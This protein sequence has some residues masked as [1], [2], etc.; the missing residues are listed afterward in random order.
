[1]SGLVASISHSPTSWCMS[2]WVRCHFNGIRIFLY[3]TQSR[4]LRHLDISACRG[5]Y[6]SE[7]QLPKL[8]SFC[9]S[10]SPLGTDLF[11][12]DFIQDKFDDRPCIYQ[13]LCT[14]APQLKY[15]NDHKL[16]PD[17]YLGIIYDELE[18]VLRGVCSCYAHRPSWCRETYSDVLCRL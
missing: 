11:D 10:R 16:S 12:V 8:E 14:G 7:M 1:M 4:S 13:V 3:K 15:L 5:V 17:W 6:L 2:S 18:Q 9:V